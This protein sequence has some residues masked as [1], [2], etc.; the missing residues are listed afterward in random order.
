MTGNSKPHDVEPVA[1]PQSLDANRVRMSFWPKGAESVQTPI[2]IFDKLFKLERF[3]PSYLKPKLGFLATFKNRILISALFVVTGV[4][5]VIGVTLEFA[6]FPK[7]KGDSAIIDNLK[8]IHFLASLAVLAVSWIFIERISKIITSP[9]LQLTKRADQI[10]RE[11]GERFAVGSSPY[12]VNGLGDEVEIEEDDSGPYDEIGGL[13]RSFNR[14]LFHLKASEARL[15]ESEEKYRFL[16]DNGPSPIFVFDANSMMILD[17]NARVEEE[18]LYSKSELLNMNFADLGLDRDR[19]ETSSKLKKLFD[20]EVAL[21]PVLQHR[22]KDGSLFMVNFQACTSR[23]LDHPAI[24]AAVWD[25]T[26]R[27]EKRAKLIQAG[28]MATLGEMATGI[29]HELNQ[30]LNVIM[31]GCDYLRKKTRPGACVTNQDVIQVTQEINSSVQRAS[32]IINHLRQFGRK[33]DETMSPTDIN[34]PISSVFNL[35]GTQLE[36]RGIK[37]ELDLDTRLPKILGDVNRLE[38]VFINLILNARDAML[39]EQVETKNGSENGGKIIT[40]RSFL[41]NERVVVTVSDTGPGIPD[42]I[43]SKIFDP[44]FTTKKTGEGTG[45]GLSISYGIV[46]DHHGTIEVDP[47][48]GKGATFRLSFPILPHGDEV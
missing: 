29:A 13:T 5:I 42:S 36:A 1:S 19:E 27:L 14:M 8:V 16:F 28:K 21:F 30:P 17:V 41:K 32:R 46:K 15:R 45:L 34:Y 24:I 25:V 23:Y 44:F 20:S 3:I 37:W 31:L 47:F 38:Q 9:L 26:E 10:S 11:A 2:S 6:V 48:A 39:S 7:L 4:V 40:I 43:V 18:Y 35:V 22:R 33:A 12:I